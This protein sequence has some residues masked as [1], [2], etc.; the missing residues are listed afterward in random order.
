MRTLEQKN[1]KLGS[2]VP[3]AWGIHGE[4]KKKKQKH[5]GRLIQTT[6]HDWKMHGSLIVH[7]P[8]EK[9]LECSSISRSDG[10]RGEKKNTKEFELLIFYFFFKVRIS[11]REHA[12][13]CWLRSLLEL[14]SALC[15][16][17][18][19]L[20]NLWLYYNCCA[21]PSTPGWAATAGNKLKKTNKQ[22]NIKIQRDFC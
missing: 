12:C 16:L 9:K 22:T 7:Q 2:N 21:L 15:P 20:H 8:N 1:K 18:F 6:L 17:E 4:T 3:L 5:R 10:T 11:A 13:A 19:L 14:P